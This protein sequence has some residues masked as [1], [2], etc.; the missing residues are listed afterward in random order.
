MLRKRNNSYYF[1]GKGNTKKESIPVITL[2]SSTNI[3]DTKKSPKSSKS[4][5]I[6]YIPLEIN[7]ENRYL[8][9]FRDNPNGFG[10]TLNIPATFSKNG[11]YYKVIGIG[12]EAFFSCESISRVIISEGIEYIKESAFAECTHLSDI[13]LPNSLTSIGKS[14]FEWCER[15]TLITY[16]GT[17]EEWDEVSKGRNWDNGTGKTY[18]G[19]YPGVEVEF[20]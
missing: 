18:L 19:D 20:V 5:E 15:L 7:E 14:A 12:R 6:K 16:N 17:E 8:I 4:P 9:G 11:T 10:F 3:K 1:T 13:E 2:N